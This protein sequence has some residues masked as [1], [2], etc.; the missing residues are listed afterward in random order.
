MCSN[1]SALKSGAITINGFYGDWADPTYKIMRVLVLALAVT[2]LYPYMPGSSSGA[3]KGI[4]IFLGVPFSLGSSSAVGNMVA[5]LVLTYTCAFQIRDRVKIGETVGDIIEKTMLVTRVR[6]VKNVA[7]TIPNGTVLSDQV[8]NYSTLS[9]RGLILH[10]AVTI[11]Y[12]APWRQVHQLLV[13]AAVRTPNIL[14]EP[15]PFVLQTA[16]DDFY[17][18]YEVNAYTNNAHAMQATYSL[19]HQNIQETFNGAGVEI[20][21]PHYRAQRDG[22]ATTIPVLSQGLGK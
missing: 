8:H 12:D 20:M 22:N 14:A 5:G 9:A 16:L 6:T 1:F 13:D 3:F 21:S 10:A 19:L 2:L 11:G 18:R 17:V 7:V 15:S 4:S